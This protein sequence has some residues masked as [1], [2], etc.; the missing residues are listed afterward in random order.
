MF[1]ERCEHLCTC[2]WGQGPWGL[3]SAPRNGGAGAWGPQML[4]VSQGLVYDSHPHSG[5]E[6]TQGSASPAALGVVSPADLD[7]R[8]GVVIISSN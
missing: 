6:G 7:L 1:P 3:G 4:P 2:L 5:P 8:S